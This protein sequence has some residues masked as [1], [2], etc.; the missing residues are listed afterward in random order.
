MKLSHH[1]TFLGIHVLINVL[2]LHKEE[3]WSEP[4]LLQI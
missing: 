3:P 4:W 1:L 2:N